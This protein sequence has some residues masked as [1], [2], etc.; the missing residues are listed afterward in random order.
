M[1]PA[2]P[3]TK[4]P[5][6][7]F[8]SGPGKTLKTVQAERAY[9]IAMDGKRTMLAVCDLQAASDIPRIAEPL[10]MGLDASVEF[11]PCMNVEELETGL[12]AFG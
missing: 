1:R 11:I 5:C 8:L 7:R 3:A 9:L 12:S 10:F 4:Y 6:G 2:A